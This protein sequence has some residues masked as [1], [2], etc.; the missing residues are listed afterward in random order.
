MTVQRDHA[1]DRKHPCQTPFCQARQHPSNTVCQPAANGPGQEWHRTPRTKAHHQSC[2]WQGQSTTQGLLSSAL[3]QWELY[4]WGTSMA[5]L[6]LLPTMCVGDPPIYIC[7]RTASSLEKNGQNE[8]DCAVDMHQ[9][10]GTSGREHT[11]EGLFHTML[12]NKF[13]KWLSQRQL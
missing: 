9:S 7:S 6:Q 2:T 11:G 4:N 13:V 8:L 10:Q 5:S 3:W 1:F 12:Q